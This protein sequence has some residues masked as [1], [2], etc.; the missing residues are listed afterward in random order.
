LQLHNCSTSRTLLLLLLLLPGY[1][2]WGLRNPSG[3]KEKLLK[4]TAQNLIYA[5]G[6]GCLCANVMQCTLL[7]L[8]HADVTTHGVAHV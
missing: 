4:Q 3:L 8:L 6:E 5:L 1:V 7:S 2:S